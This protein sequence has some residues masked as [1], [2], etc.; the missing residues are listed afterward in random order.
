[1]PQARSLGFLL[2]ARDG[3]ILIFANNLDVL[4]ERMLA[5]DP[6]LILSENGS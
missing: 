4:S 1:M 3:Q 2:S 6:P 5:A